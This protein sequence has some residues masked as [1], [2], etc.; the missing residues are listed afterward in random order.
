M[1]T[2]L[3]GFFPIPSCIRQSDALARVL[4]YVQYFMSHSHIG[5][6]IP[7][8]QVHCPCLVNRFLR[9]NLSPFKNLRTESSKPFRHNGLL[10]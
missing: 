1:S 4:S 5:G 7:N 3:R 2:I 10:L 8:G 6:S 9:Q